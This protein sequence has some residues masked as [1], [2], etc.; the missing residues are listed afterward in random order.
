MASI[1]VK[2]LFVFAVAALVLSIVALVRNSDAE[3]AREKRNEG[4][5]GAVP[6][7]AGSS[8]GGA[9][10]DYRRALNRLRARQQQDMA[11]MSLRMGRRNWRSSSGFRNSLSNPLW[12]KAQD[13]LLRKA[14]FEYDP[15]S[16]VAVRGAKNPNPRR[17]SNS[18]CKGTVA[19]NSAG[20]TDMVWVWGQFVD[21]DLDLTGG[22]SGDAAETLDM[23]TDP[24]DPNEDFSDQEYT[25]SFTRSEFLAVSAAE[26]FRRHPNG[27]SSFL[28]CTN[29]YGSSEERE[30]ALRAFDGSGKLKTGLSAGG[31]EVT[32][33]KNPLGLPNAMAGMN[34]PPEDFYLAGDV[35]G[36]ENCNLIAM[37]TLWVR[38]HNRLCDQFEAEGAF[39]SAA[40]VDREEMIFQHA[41]RTVIGMV[42]AIT[43]FEFLPLL[44]GPQ[45]AAELQPQ[46]FPGLQPTVNPSVST[47]FSTAGY[48]FGHSMVTEF[49]NRVVDP[50]NNPVDQDAAEFPPVEQVSL[51]TAFFNPSLVHEHGPSAFLLGL[52][53]KKMKQVDT[54]LVN[55]LRNALFGPPS[56]G[57]L[58]DL[59]AL[60]LQRG[61]DHG[62][63]GYNAMRQAF[64]LPT[65]ASFAELPIEQ[66]LKAKFA[67]LYDSPDD[68][69]PWIGLLAEQHLEGAA[70]GPLAAAIIKEQ[71][72]RTQTGD[73]FY[74]EVD[75][76]FTEAERDAIRRTRL[77]E[78]IARNVLGSHHIPH[79]FQI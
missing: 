78:V 24:A 12:G 34:S 8:D 56:A 48:R 28:D 50:A 49:A 43:Y 36:N 20:L 70:V 60:N 9:F 71:F 30:T 55:D 57:K 40:G 2:L 75:E 51:G 74:F 16:Q 73:R 52:V 41:R 11:S 15:V 77:G 32:L 5:G 54:V 44:I 31:L 47:E 69:D 21:H 53:T 59:A 66:E 61:R 27:I 72:V 79:A 33:P 7:G 62:L 46:N 23:K 13:W 35:R 6:S 42:A 37:H 17:V 38:E 67:D 10:D 76:A 22:Q 45:L 68:I 58:L 29:V 18:L 19:E 3:K 26:G 64:G 1:A 4:A 39:S 65:V 25:I 14:P 63:P